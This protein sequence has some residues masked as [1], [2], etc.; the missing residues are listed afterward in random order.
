MRRAG[1]CRLP[2]EILGRF[3]RFEQPTLR[4]RE[5]FV[6]AA[7]LRLETADRRTRFD[8]PPLQ[9]LA[10]LFGLPPFARELLV[11]LGQA[12]VLGGDVLQLRFEGDDRLLVAMV[13]GV[14]RG[15]RSRRLR[16]GNF[17]L[18]RLGGHRRELATLVFDARA[19]FLDVPLGFEDASSFRRVAAGH[20]VSA[21][22]QLARD[23]CNRHIHRSAALGGLREGFGN[24]GITDR[25]A[26]H[27]GVR[28][29]CPGHRGEPDHPGR[30]LDVAQGN[31]CQGVT[32]ARVVGARNDQEAASSRALFAHEVESRLARVPGARR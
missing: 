12:A 1:V 8:L 2:A 20:Q 17:E 11:F 28:P 6:G 31:G 4:D 21:A 26:D 32:A 9:R 24:P 15:D 14:Q 13:F 27:R 16:D 7:L 10:L 23:G 19:Q 18:G 3:P 29:V 25:P 22:K 30:S 5:T